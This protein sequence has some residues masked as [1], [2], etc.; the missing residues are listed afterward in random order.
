MDNS[1]CSAPSARVQTGGPAASPCLVG[2]SAVRHRC[3]L[4]S[5]FDCGLEAARRCCPRACERG[6]GERPGPFFY[7]P[8]FHYATYTTI[9]TKP[10]HPHPHPSPY[11]DCTTYPDHTQTRRV[12][13]D[14]ERAHSLARSC[15][16]ERPSL[17]RPASASATAPLCSSP[18]KTRTHPTPLRFHTSSSQFL[19]FFF[20]LFFIFCLCVVFFFFVDLGRSTSTKYDGQHTAP[21]LLLTGSPSSLG[22]RSFPGLDREISLQPPAPGT[23]RGAN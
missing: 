1:P 11:T 13:Q 2:Q 7:L 12:P 5:V 15:T 8:L 23:I 9:A 22:H 18:F 19:F 14:S 6:T 4:V 16:H 3:R 17:L 20:F 21:S 10:F